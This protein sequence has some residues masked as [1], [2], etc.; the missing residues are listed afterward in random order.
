MLVF[1]KIGPSKMGKLF[2]KNNYIEMVAKL[3]RSEILDFRARR[4]RRVK[5]FEP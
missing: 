1:Q 2:I 3:F 5:R 4:G